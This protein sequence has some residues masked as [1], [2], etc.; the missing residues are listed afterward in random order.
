MGKQMES[1]SEEQI[2]EI[3]EKS[4]GKLTPYNKNLGNGPSHY[5]EVDG[6]VGK[7]GFISAISH[8]FCDE[9]N[10]VR[11]TSEGFLKTCLQ[12]DVGA[13]LLPFLEEGKEEELEMTIQKAIDLKPKS[14]KFHEEKEGKDEEYWIVQRKDIQ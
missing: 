12:Y 10:R 13:D 6:F 9:C 8:K 11:V 1:Y 3:L 5:Y 7:I 2:I 14:H 4:F